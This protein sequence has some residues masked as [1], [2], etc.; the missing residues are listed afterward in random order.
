MNNIYENLKEE[1][2][3]RPVYTIGL[4]EMF[5]Y[6]VMI[7][8]IF[9][10][11]PLL[12]NSNSNTNFSMTFLC[13]TFSII[14]FSKLFEIQILIGNLEFY[15]N[16]SIILLINCFFLLIPYYF[17]DFNIKLISFTI[18]NGTFGYLMPALSA[19][20][21]KL[22]NE[23]YRTLLMSVYKV[24]TYL[25]SIISLIFSIFISIEKVRFFNI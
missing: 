9:I 15:D 23:K 24:P 1:L 5:V 8:Y 19:F 12:L 4:I 3:Y 2:K 10:W 14:I 16:F 6:T 20:K 13:F 17:D 7:V 25:L 22:L 18:V 11:T 21:S